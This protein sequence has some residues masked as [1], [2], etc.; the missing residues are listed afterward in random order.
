MAGE[1]PVE[2]VDVGRHVVL[3]ENDE[4]LV[5]R[6]RGAL[7]PGEMGAIAR[8]HDAR[9]L[10]RGRLF[11]LVDVTAAEPP[12]YAARQELK[13][14]P[15]KLPPHWIAYVGIPREYSIVLDLIVRAASV[16]SSSKIVHRYFPDELAAR[17]WLDEMRAK[18][19]ANA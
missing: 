8:V 10:E 18:F 17:A 4:L 15:K 1:L 3:F 7:L 16:L 11:V 12:S 6:M 19:S 9:L 13:E 2:V 14:R 5:L